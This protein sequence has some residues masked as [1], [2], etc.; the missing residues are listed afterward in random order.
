[1]RSIFY[2]VKKQHKII[3]TNSGFSLSV[4]ET[5][6]FEAL[7]W[8]A[9]PSLVEA[10]GLWSPCW[11]AAKATKNEIFNLPNKTSLW[12]KFWTPE[13]FSYTSRTFTIQTCDAFQYQWHLLQQL[14]Q[15]MGW[16]LHLWSHFI[17]FFL[18]P[19]SSNQ[20]S[21][22]NSTRGFF[23]FYRNTDKDTAGVMQ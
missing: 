16:T 12:W 13:E 20:V 4:R 15:W 9:G 6:C 10:F 18:P 5:H 8:Q 7:T 14:I 23:C 3:K 1:M 22:P 11:Q 21:C 19:L 2:F 17:L